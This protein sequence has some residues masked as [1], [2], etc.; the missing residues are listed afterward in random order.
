MSDKV[1]RTA[2]PTE[3]EI[4]ERLQSVV[5]RIAKQR[6]ADGKPCRYRNL[7]EIREDFERVMARMQEIEAKALANLRGE[8]H[9]K[10]G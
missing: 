1:D 9:P 7:E 10:E 8:T 3:E 6:L 5:E 4:V 2:V